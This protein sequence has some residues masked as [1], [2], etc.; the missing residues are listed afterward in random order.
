ME[1]FDRIS[2]IFRSLWRLHLNIALINFFRQFQT[3]FFCSL[4]FIFLDLEH[5]Y[6]CKFFGHVGD[7]ITAILPKKEDGLLGYDLVFAEDFISNR[8]SVV[9]MNYQSPIVLVVST[10]D[11]IPDGV[12]VATE[13]MHRD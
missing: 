10:K 11:L 13:N 3:G 7:V 5:A 6:L 2:L 9:I 12:L 4:A 8:I 1:L